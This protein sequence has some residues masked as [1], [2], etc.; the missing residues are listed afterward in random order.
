MY[1]VLTRKGGKYRDVSPLA[2][3]TTVIALAPLGNCDMP[4]VSSP[5]QQLNQTCIGK[6]CMH[7]TCIQERISMDDDFGHSLEK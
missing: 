5:Q 1:Y 7:S 6:S 3:T 4:T 2:S